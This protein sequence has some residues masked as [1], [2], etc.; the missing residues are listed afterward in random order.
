MRVRM[1]AEGHGSQAIH[2]WRQTGLCFTM[3]NP[4]AM[5]GSHQ[6][7]VQAIA[8]KSTAL[9]NDAGLKNYS[10]VL[11]CQLGPRPFCLPGTPW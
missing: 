1:S 9:T 8:A 10:K 4:D 2:S 11:T 7:H 3:H 6:Q 5:T